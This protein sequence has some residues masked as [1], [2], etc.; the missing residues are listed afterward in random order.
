M[1]FNK[2]EIVL[3]SDEETNHQN[4]NKITRHMS[5]KKNDTG[6]INSILSSINNVTISNTNNDK[7]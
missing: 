1:Y 6:K 2:N 4:L 5:E 7:L 3:S